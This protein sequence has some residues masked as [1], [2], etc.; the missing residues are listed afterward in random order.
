MK[1]FG[2][3]IENLRIVF[4][5]FLIFLTQF[6][7][8]Q[9]PTKKSLLIGVGNYPQSGNWASLCS[10]NDLKLLNI[11]LINV[12]F[13]SRNIEILK[14]DSATKKGIL[15]AIHRFENR[16]NTG[17][18]AYFHFSGH[19]QQKAD[20]EGDEIDGLDECIVPFD[21]PKN[22]VLGIY[23]GENLITD[24]ELNTIFLKIRK[25]LGEKGQLIISL[26]ACHSGTGIRGNIQARGST[27]I[28]ASE[29]YLN[30]IA[31]KVNQKEYNKIQKSIEKTELAPMVAIFGSAQHQLNYE[32]CTSNGEHYGSL[33]YAISKGLNSNKPALSIRNFFDLIK[34]EMNTIA[35]LQQ[36]QIEGEQDRALFNGKLTT[37]SNY[38]LPIQMVSESEVKIN[39]GMLQGIF[40]NTEFQVFEPYFL[41]KKDAKPIASG[42]VV[43]SELNSA[44]I[45]LKNNIE[46]ES[47]LKAWFVVSKFGIENQKLSLSTNNLNEPISI[48]IKQLITKFPFLDLSEIEPNLIFKQTKSGKKAYLTIESAQGTSIDSFEI[49]QNKLS[50]NNLKSIELKLKRFL[51][52]K[53]IRNL[54]TEDAEL[55]V[56][57]EIMKISNKELSPLLAGIDGL[58]R[59]QLNT[60][61]QFKVKNFGIHPAYFTLLDIQPDNL[62]NILLPDNNTTPEEMRVLP[63]QEILIP[64]VFQVGYPLGNELFKLVA[65]NK[66]IDLK[67]PLC[68]KSNKNVSDFEQL[69]KC[70]E[71]NTN[72][73]TRL[74]SPIS[75]ATDINIFSDTFIIEN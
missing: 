72:S 15:D 61:F 46:K 39:A 56:R 68:I 17:D 10:T 42:L 26:D 7:F 58:K 22:F 19:G 25:K 37:K 33:S 8:T 40:E 75:I 41:E 45:K 60:T 54:K 16:L 73:N 48:Q 51:Q 27:T 1:N 50:E 5:T 12:G 31:S 30:K 44:T 69:F 23:E 70:F 71:D 59:L 65:A 34:I 49:F 2:K 20:L 43:R 63:D 52:G 32:M 53:V 29:E 4:L 55:D 21:S 66:P 35:P 28:M 47:V 13:E 57:F 36:P 14:E 74:K 18:I 9:S 38:F 67:T 64:I 3:L 24:D 6:G 11:A 62:I